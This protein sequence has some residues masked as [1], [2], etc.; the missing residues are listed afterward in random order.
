MDKTAIDAIANLAIAGCK[1]QDVEGLP[2]L[3]GPSNMN[4]QVLHSLMARPMRINH[5]FTTTDYAS[6]TAYIARFSPSTDG[7]EHFCCLSGDGKGPGLQAHYIFDGHSSDG[8]PGN[9]E[10]SASFIPATSVE[11][12]RWTSNSGRLLTQSEFAEFIEN[13]IPDI[14]V[15]KDDKDSPSGGA[16]LSMAKELQLTSSMEVD[17][18]VD[19][20]SGGVSFQFIEKVEGKQAGKKITV[21]THFY[22]AI[23]MHTGGPAYVV[24]V[25]FRFRRSE[26]KVKM[27]Y[28]LFRHHKLYESALDTL[29]AAL[30]ESLGQATTIFK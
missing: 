26:Q 28:E 21:P 2:V 3:V 8:T 22:I 6:F 23:P 1:I 5:H 25:L 12:E 30:G 9:R 27:E 19:R 7:Q 10:H 11:W 20:A 18:R 4:A 29:Q 13:N 17:S 15:P 24:K 14:H 16:M